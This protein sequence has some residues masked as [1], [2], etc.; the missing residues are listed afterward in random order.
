M[1][2]NRTGLTLGILAGAAVAAFAVSKLGKNSIKK[3]GERTAELRDSLT[4][5]LIEIRNLKKAEN[6]FI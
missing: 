2:S 4:N 1:K 3:L 5:Q 6:G